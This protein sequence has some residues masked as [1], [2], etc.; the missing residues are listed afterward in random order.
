MVTRLPCRTLAPHFQGQTEVRPWSVSS[1]QA[2]EIR[3]PWGKGRATEDDRRTAP[4]ILQLIQL[5]ALTS[6]VIGIA[7]QLPAFPSS[8]SFK[9]SLLASGLRA[10]TLPAAW[11]VAASSI[12]HVL[13]CS[14]GTG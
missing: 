1:P 4:V 6:P 7:A 3:I 12:G 2:R 11:A 9:P 5:A 8:L 14:A 13:T 10:G